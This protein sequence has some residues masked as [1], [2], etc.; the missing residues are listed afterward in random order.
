M[1]EP[2]Q[3]FSKRN[4]LFVQQNFRPY[5]PTPKSC[6]RSYRPIPRSVPF[7]NKYNFPALAW[8]WVSKS[9]I[10]AFRVKKLQTK[11]HP[12]SNIRYLSPVLTKKKPWYKKPS[13]FEWI[14]EVPYLWWQQ[15][16]QF[17]FEASILCYRLKKRGISVL[18]KRHGQYKIQFHVYI[19]KQDDLLVI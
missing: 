17:S 18:L 12:E 6:F 7:T 5:R 19:I 14:C 1:V 9:I 8:L 3:I 4:S 2:V 16:F 15:W 13:N 10:S 11:C